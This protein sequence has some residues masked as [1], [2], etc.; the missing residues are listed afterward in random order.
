MSVL[1]PLK[2]VIRRLGSAYVR[3]VIAAEYS[4][5][6]FCGVNERPIEFAFLLRQLVAA[7]P[8]TV[9][10]VGTGLTSLPHLLRTCGFIVTAT[11]NIEDYWPSGMVNR[12]Y[13][14]VNDDITK[15]S[16]AGSYDAITCISVLEH[17]QAS[18]EAVRSMYKLL[19]P[20]GR[21]VLTC[22]YNERKYA[23]NVYALPES[24]VTE[25]FPFVTQAY[26]RAQV[27]TWLVDSPFELLEQEYWQFFEGEYWTCGERVLPPRRVGVDDRHQLTC[28]LLGKPR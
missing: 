10:D 8:K 11:D 20:G 18:R 23:K 3:R 5:Q 4:E 15:S 27:N 7:W 14:I 13:H 12:H 21:L 6:T 2:S 26:S 19:S 16:L 1:S 9:L 24:R 25:R 22:P 28:L 17:I